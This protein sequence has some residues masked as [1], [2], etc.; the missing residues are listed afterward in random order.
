MKEIVVP[1]IIK[2]YYF[3]HQINLVVLVLLKLILVVCLEFL[4]PY[5]EALYEFFSFT[6]W[7]SWISKVLWCVHK[8]TKQIAKKCE[9]AMGLCVVSYW[10]NI[11]IWLQSCTLMHQGVTLVMTIWASLTIWKSFEGYM[12]L[13]HFWIMCIQSSSWHSLVMWFHWYGEDVL[14]LTLSTLFWSIYEIW[15]LNFKW[16]KGSWNI[17]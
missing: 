10:N 1:F 11:N 16:V 4:L 7:V 13:C 6:Q 12:R 3:I 8:K 15:W 2:M 5:L 9:D 17:H 14:A